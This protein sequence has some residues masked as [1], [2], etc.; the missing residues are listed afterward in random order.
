MK[1]HLK[2]W[3]LNDKYREVRLA[4]ILIRL[5]RQIDLNM[6]NSMQWAEFST[7]I[8]T[9]VNTS[10]NTQSRSEEVRNYQ[11]DGLKPQ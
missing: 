3:N 9:K 1:E 7:Y 6:S 8:M 10:N 5:F 2:D 4:R 11:L